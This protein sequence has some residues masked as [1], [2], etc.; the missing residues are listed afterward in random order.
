[1]KKLN[2]KPSH[3]VGGGLATMLL[4]LSSIAASAETLD[5]AWRIALA[6]DLTLAAAA[7]RVSAAQA[8][9]GAARAERR[10]IVSASVSA[11]ELD[12]T[13][14]FD[15][16][17]AGMPLEMPLLDGSRL[18]H[19]GASVTMPLYTAG[20][21]GAGVAAAEAQLESEQQASNALAQQVKLAVAERY[22][23][24]LRA[25][26]GVAVADERV[27][28]LAA[29][30]RDV[31][32]MYRAGSVPRND[33]LAATVSL[34]D[35]EQRRLQAQ[36][37]L[38]LAR[39]AYNRGLGRPLDAPVELDSA[40]PD[41]DRVIDEASVEALTALAIER[42]SEPRQLASAADTLASQAR[43]AAAETRP[44]LG[45]TG[46]YMRLEN[47]FLNRDDY[48]AVGLGVQWTP[49]DGGR[50]RA[51]AESLSQQSTAIRSQQR[52]LESLIA[53]EVRQAWL[54]RSETAARVA[55]AERAVEQAEENLRVARDRYRNGEGTN[56]EVLDA[57]ALRAM[58]LDNFDAARYDAALSAFRLAY[59]VGML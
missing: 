53:L 55:V 30:V 15:F 33:F 28:S 32:D 10:P 21:I 13:P 49:F 1:M 5:D 20:R 16:S 2:R 58:S 4:A 22:I 24:V 11:L 45:L 6:Q 9:V 19:A 43:A 38:D 40:L 14:A 42:R 51:R 18:V 23:A 52:D 54:S 48:V 50:S 41:L 56:T 34:A 27:A 12:R 47:E 39:G 57:E 31:E 36:N 7:S 3:L 17:G 37:G 29:H 46:G 59:A 44:Q 25:E 35:A 8:G 26:S